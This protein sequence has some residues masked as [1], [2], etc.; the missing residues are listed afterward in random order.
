MPTTA[1]SLRSLADERGSDRNFIYLLMLA[2]KYGIEP[3]ALHNSLMK[4]KGSKKS[5]C[6]SLSIELRE[7][8][9]NTFC[10]MFSRN[11]RP[12]A[13]TPISEYSLAKL[14]QVPPELTRLL[15]DRDRRSTAADRSQLE[16]RIVDLHVGLRHVN[17]KARVIDKSVVR[18]VESRD[19]LPLVVCSATLSDGTGQ[20]RLPLWN[21]QIHSVAKNDTV[22]IREATVGYFRGE[23]QL[24]IPR[25]TGSISIVH[26]ADD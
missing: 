19:G 9:D 14:R 10:F 21:S 17:L 11:D 20:I 22:M 4:A 18:A 12:V 16:R 24:S 2:R 3:I 23:L 1:S 25:R 6:G 5:K 7:L 8:R 13:Q 15:N 26:P